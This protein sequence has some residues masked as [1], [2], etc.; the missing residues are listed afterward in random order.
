M[1]SNGNA[2][3]VFSWF[4]APVYVDNT[5]CSSGSDKV[6]S[7]SEANSAAHIDLN[8]RYQDPVTLS[9]ASNAATEKKS[10]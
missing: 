6:F 9:I 3:T 7:D 4:F 2:S 8:Y 1:R 10:C 5:F